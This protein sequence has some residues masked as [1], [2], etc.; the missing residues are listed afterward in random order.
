MFSVKSFP[1]YSKE[2][3]KNLSKWFQKQYW[4]F[5]EQGTIMHM[6]ILAFVYTLF[7]GYLLQ[8]TINSKDPNLQGFQT[9]QLTIWF[10]W[11]VFT[12]YFAGYKRGLTRYQPQN[13]K[14]YLTRKFW[15]NYQKSINNIED[16]EVAQKVLAA[17]LKQLEKEK[18]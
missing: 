16:E 14:K 9:Y 12:I 2:K 4:S 15:K 6:I 1:A 10:I 13:T 11:M 17:A 7:L 18:V 8:P 5:M 3:G